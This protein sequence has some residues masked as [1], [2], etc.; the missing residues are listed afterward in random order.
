MLAATLR[1]L[2]S[3]SASQ[4]ANAAQLRSLSAVAL[5]ATEPQPQP[6]TQSAQPP[7][8][9]AWA[10][11]LGV[12][13]NTW[14]YACIA[15]PSSARPYQN[16]MPSRTLLAN[17]IGHWVDRCITTRP[18]FE[19]TSPEPC[20]ACNAVTPLTCA[21]RYAKSAP[22]MVSSSLPGAPQ[23]GRGQRGVPLAASG[24][25]LRGGQR[26]QDAQ[27]P[28]HGAWL[29]NRGPAAV[30]SRWGRPTMLPCCGCFL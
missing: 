1:C 6:R 7:A 25:G 15:D 5:P 20:G 10:S 9:P 23:P 18:S 26:A 21:A 14:T 28:Q 11:Q 8:T 19:T 22:S 13:R 12:V 3:R 24:A 2:C 30:S 27:R 29:A 16:I 4:P 17:G